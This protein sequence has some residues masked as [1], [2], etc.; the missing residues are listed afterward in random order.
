VSISQQYEVKTHKKAAHLQVW[1]LIQR[2]PTEC[3][4]SEC[5]REDSS[6]RR[7]WP[8]MGCCTVKKKSLGSKREWKVK[9]YNS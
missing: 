1:S 3:G 6:I 4:V 9:S 2:S 8:T 5:D 7:L